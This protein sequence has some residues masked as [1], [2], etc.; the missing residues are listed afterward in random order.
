M[1]FSVTKFVAIHDGSHRKLAQLLYLKSPGK[2]WLQMWLG[3]GALMGWPWSCPSSYFNSVFFL[4]AL[5]TGRLPLSCGRSVAKGF[6]LANFSNPGRAKGTLFQII[7]ANVPG[8]ICMG[9]A[10][11]WIEHPYS[12]WLGS[13]TL[14]RGAGEST[15]VTHQLEGASQ[16]E[17]SK[18]LGQD[19]RQM[20]WGMDSCWF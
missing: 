3:P 12:D 1:F 10:C 7:S 18:C 16:S 2:H 13:L 17:N 4:M 19:V 5:F 20:H 9:L 14:P 11:I 15:S 8:V 6:H